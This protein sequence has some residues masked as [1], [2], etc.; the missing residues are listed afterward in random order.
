MN[1]FYLFLVF[2]AYGVTSHPCVF[3][4]GIDL[5]ELSRNYGYFVVGHLGTKFNFLLNICA[6]F[7]NTR[8]LPCNGDRSVPSIM[9]HYKNYTI[10]NAISRTAEHPK[11]VEVKWLDPNNHGKGVRLIYK[12]GRVFEQERGLYGSRTEIEI[13][14]SNNEYAEPIFKSQSLD[15]LTMVFHFRMKSKYACPK[16]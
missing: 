1:I 14:C 5:R 4:K 3:E 2:F 10:C 12:N 11:D 9:F 15:L 8:Y 6:P 7:E 13:L 16:Q